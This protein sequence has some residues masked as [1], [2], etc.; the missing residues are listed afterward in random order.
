MTIGIV[1]Y[2][3]GNLGSLGSAL[4]E[5]GIKFI[6][7][8]DP[9]RILKS[10]LILIPGV[11]SM[12]S[13]MR[14]IRDS[15]LDKAIT[16]HASAGKAVLGICLGMHLLATSGLEGGETKGLNLIPG[17]ILKLK[18]TESYRVPHMGWDE[19]NYKDTPTSVYF[20][21]SYYFKPRL[22]SEIQV[23]SAFEAGKES[24]P[25]HIQ[26]GNVAGIQFHP[27][28]SGAAG[29]RILLDTIELLIGQSA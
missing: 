18:S 25:A 23:L 27:E 17:E 11:G 28:K 21:H 3:A 5:L 1:D 15:N 6:V 10:N 14:N 9:S 20:A 4:N 2:Q 12:F 16:H 13:G 22:H 24:Y 26:F 8:D 7:S 19:I 29:L